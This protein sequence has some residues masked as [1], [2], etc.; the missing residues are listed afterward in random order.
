MAEQKIIS[1]LP[2]GTASDDDSV[3]ILDG[4]VTK[5]VLLSA[6]AAYINGKVTTGVSSVDGATGAVD[7]SGSYVALGTQKQWSH[8]KLWDAALGSPAYSYAALGPSGQ[9][10]GCMLFDGAAHENAYGF[11][12]LPLVDTFDLWL[13]WG[14][15][16][17][18]AGDAVWQAQ[19][20][21]M[22]P[23]NTLDG[24]T[25]GSQITITS[26]AQNVLTETRLLAGITRGTATS[27][28]VKI[29]RRGDVAG[30]TINAVDLGAVAVYA[31]KAA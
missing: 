26:P 10:H 5:R 13:L 15:P 20:E 28:G 12:T 3:P 7:L 8:S 21:F 23:N 31:T 11:L 22:G 17:A 4:G 14:N 6:L 1:D 25:A 18:T 2:V 9:R 24:F 19:Y 29:G 16:S 27:M 30:D